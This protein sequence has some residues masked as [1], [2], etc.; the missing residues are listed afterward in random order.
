MIDDLPVAQGFSRTGNAVEVGRILEV[1]DGFIALLDGT[2][3]PDPPR[4]AWLLGTGN[5]YLVVPHREDFP[6]N[7]PRF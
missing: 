4:G 2:L 5:G 3:R 1:A 6:E 7:A